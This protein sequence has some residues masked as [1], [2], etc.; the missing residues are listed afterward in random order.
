MP[1][2]Q[3]PDSRF[4]YGTYLAEMKNPVFLSYLKEE[5]KKLESLRSVLK[6][7]AE[8]SKR[9]E[10]SLAEVEEKLSV[11]REVQNEMQ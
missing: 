4:L 8:H 1:V 3:I 2:K 9:A 6:Q 10:D 7:Q 5:E 11:N